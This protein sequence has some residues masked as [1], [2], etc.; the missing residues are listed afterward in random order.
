[1]KRWIVIATILV[2]GAGALFLVRRNQARAATAPKTV[3]VT[4][5]SVVQEA[6]AIGSVVPDQEISVKSKVPGLVAVVH[7]KVGDFVHAGDPLN[8]VRPDPPPLERAEAERGVDLARVSEAGAASDLERAEGLAKQGLI[9]DKELN[10]A[11]RDHQSA[12][13]RAQLEAEKLDLLKSGRATV[14]GAT[15]SN[16]IVAPTTGTVLTLEV[17]PGDPVVPLTSYQEGTVLLTMADMGELLFKGTVDEVDVGKLAVGQPVN[18]TVGALPNAKVEGVLTRISPKAR[19]EDSTTLFDIEARITPSDGV[20]LRAGYSANAKIIFARAESVLVLPER[21]VKY[22]DGKASVR[23]PGSG[24][25]A[26]EKSIE[27]G[28]SD[29]LTVEVKSGLNKGALVL[30]PAPSSLAKK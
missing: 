29:G 16:R 13:L 8:D 3:E 4:T 19:K 11:R 20:E 30:E 15:V 23:V 12:K 27:T 2:V 24:G 25:K 6:L 22:T 10:D 5:G 1:M 21:L 26:E 9:S 7:V 18:F 14:G 17:H 28:L